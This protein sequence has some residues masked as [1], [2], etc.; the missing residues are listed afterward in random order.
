VNAAK[1]V[2]SRRIRPQVQKGMNMLK[3]NPKQ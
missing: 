1:V 3:A 2:A